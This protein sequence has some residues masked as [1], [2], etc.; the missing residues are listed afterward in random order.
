MKLEVKKISLDNLKADAVVVPLFKDHKQTPSLFVDL[1]RAF[2][3]TLQS[4]VSVVNTEEGKITS[5]LVQGK[6]GIIR[7]L[8][9]SLGEKEKVDLEKI[10]K[11]GGKLVQYFQCN[12]LK[13]NIVL[14]F[15]YGIQ[16][17]MPYE[18]ARAFAEGI[19]LGSYSFDSFKTDEEAKK[20]KEIQSITLVPEYDKDTAV[21]EKAFVFAEKVCTNTNW[22]RELVNTPANVA[23]PAYIGEIAQ[24]VAKKGGF[25]ATILG[26]NDLKKEKMGCILAV[27]KGSD[28]E[29]KLIVLE[30][31]A[32]RKSASTIALVGKGVTFDSGGINLKPTGYLETM[33]DDKAGAIAVLGT[34]KAAAELQLD[35]NIIAVMPCVEN[36]INGSAS[37]PSDIIKAASGKS[38]EIGNTDA[39]GR[40]VLADALHYVTRYKPD[41]IIDIATL[42]G[43]SFVALGPTIT[44]MVGNDESLM[45]QLSD[46]GQ[47]TYERVW[48]LPL[49][50]E[51]DEHIKSDVADIKNLG[52]AKGGAGVIAGA[53]FLKQFIGKHKWIH[54]DIGGTARAESANEYLSKGPTGVG[55][56]LLI[57][58]LRRQK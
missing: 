26:L 14:S 42:T 17:I 33:K 55:V 2:G 11:L 16:K 25:K 9:I 27:S 40:L 18:I 4:L 56:R 50:E 6:H 35:I 48:Q 53:V 45:K 29:P 46:A 47:H 36:M 28:L 43:A 30:Y 34:I 8:F 23:T 24:Q 37:R 10:R 38:V 20:K 1:D 44:C 39:E 49:Y 21:L 52:L 3:K 13:N 12:Q 51:F 32:K 7:I 41:A 15:Q 5:T 19:L 31:K 22:V 58:F 54:L 57:E